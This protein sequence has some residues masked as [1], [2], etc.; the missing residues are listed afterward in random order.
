MPL[1]N[2]GSI[3]TFAEE[4]ENQQLKFCHAAM[5]QPQCSDLKSVLQTLGKSAQKRVA[6]VKRVRREN[7]TEM[8]LETLQGFSRDPF[9]LEFPDPAALPPKEIK[10]AIIRMD[11]RAADYYEKAAEKL[12]GQT[13]VARALKN[14]KKKHLKD[15]KII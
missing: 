11:N 3:L 9:V 5:N 15:L 1:I 2:F 7:V 8:I 6:E 4:I 14:L 12:K 13:D 10:S